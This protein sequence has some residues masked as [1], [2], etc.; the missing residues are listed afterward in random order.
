MK[1]YTFYTPSHE[2]FLNEWFI[3]SLK[4]T[5]QDV[6]FVVK[7]FDQK[8]NT[9]KFMDDG[10]ND[11]MSDKIDYIL[12]SI[13][14]T[15]EGEYFIHADCDIQFFKN[16]KENLKIINYKMF[17]ISAQSDMGSACCGFMIIKS[18]AKIKKLFQD[19]KILIKKKIFPNDQ[20]AL[21]A[22]YKNYDIS[23]CLLDYQYFSVW[24]SNGG[25]V[26]NGE[27]T[28]NIPNNLILHHAN[29][30]VGI[31]NKINLLKK[32]KHSQELIINE[33]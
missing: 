5:N 8:C 3:P 14:V 33:N 10:W 17:D 31:E 9:G 24:M 11:T 1:I 4:N 21:N 18:N 22:I 7:K 2:V 19:I 30:T 23:L 28:K 13:D 32:I 25:K 16:I 26:W 20:I 15:P 27:E 12:Y 6:E 29:F